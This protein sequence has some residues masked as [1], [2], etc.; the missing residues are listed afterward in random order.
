MKNL[1][2]N[3]QIACLLT[4]W[5]V[6]SGCAGSAPLTTEQPAAEPPPQL[7]QI[8]IEPLY[9][10]SATGV[11]IS[12][13]ASAARVSFT[14]VPAAGQFIKLVAPDG[15]Y[16]ETPP[17]WD[18]GA[19]GDKVLPLVLATDDGLE[20]SV[21]P[22]S[23]Y[24]G[25]GIALSLKLLNEQPPSD[26]L[27]S[28][29]A[30]AEN[31]SL[32]EVGSDRVELSWVE[33]CSGDFNF[34]GSVDGRDLLPIAE[35]LGQTYDTG[36]SEVAQDRLYWLDGNGDGAVTAQDLQF[37]QH[38]Y[39][40]SIAGYIVSH[41]DDIVPG[42]NEHDLTVMHQHGQR[43]PDLPA[44]YSIVVAGS[45]A[46]AW[47]IAAV[48][49][50]GNE[51]EPI[52]LTFDDPVNT[53]P[54]V[55]PVD[56]SVNVEI[57]GLELLDITGLIPDLTEPSK[58]GSRVIDPIETIGQPV[59]A[60][61]IPIGDN[62]F[63]FT[64]IPRDQQLLL[65]VQYLPVKNLITGQQV[66]PTPGPSAVSD[67]LSE[68]VSSAV[69]F[70]LSPGLSGTTEMNVDI[71]F[72]ERELGGYCVEVYTEILAPDGGRSALHT[73]LDYPD[74]QLKLDLDLD[75]DFAEEWEA[76]DDDR[77]GVSNLWLDEEQLMSKL[78]PGV[79]YQVV[80]S[81]ADVNPT[82]GLIRLAEISSFDPLEINLP[83]TGTIDV[84]VHE[85]AAIDPDIDPWNPIPDARYLLNV[86]AY[87]DLD[88]GQVYFFADTIE[89]YHEPV[90]NPNPGDPAYS[91]P[92][93]GIVTAKTE[94]TI[95]VEQGN[96][97]N[98]ITYDE[99]TEWYS[100]YGVVDAA[101]IAIGDYVLVEVYLI[102]DRWLAHWV[103]Q[104]SQ[105][106]TPWSDP[107]GVW[108]F[109]GVTN[110]I[111]DEYILV[112]YAGMEFTIYFDESTVWLFDFGEGSATDLSAG[113]YVHCEAQNTVDGMLAL[114]IL[115]LP[116]DINPD[117]PPGD[118][119]DP[120]EDR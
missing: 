23:N 41:N 120:L 65:D 11:S 81:I 3:W 17:Q 102:G 98:V 53:P 87:E 22:L 46:G 26:S 113:D 62:R 101:A 2:F 73:S 100:D 59:V 86:M 28:A 43:R 68:L 56:L 37:I 78:T 45:L 54:A 103:Q 52:T 69:P 4:S 47:S 64:N 19:T 97:V 12:R 58:I 112:E 119:G 108:S 99:N 33:S 57:T 85:F 38:N 80:A 111:A 79:P 74:A 15:V 76:L 84:W 48:D 60:H 117:D 30:L 83:L 92:L 1:R 42:D 50:N 96:E 55:G 90:D 36:K 27:E 13:S 91:W 7:S 39:R 32:T 14:T 89:I 61:A 106:I 35:C 115:Q 109:D 63:E 31:V 75:G 88:S 34:D 66:G 44:H 51:G 110:A 24:D 8:A 104:F 21:V 94:S 118:P 67:T 10:S 49:A 107:G 5:V 77:N 105:P 114:L 70:E 72:V 71:S 6:L 82:T 25:G 29:F 40:S 95:T 9:G 18:E 16:F 20:V 116:N 93:E